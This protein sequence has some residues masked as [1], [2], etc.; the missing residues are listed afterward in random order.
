MTDEA[1]PMLEDI[2]APWREWPEWD[3]VLARMRERDRGYN[4]R[5]EIVAI[6]ALCA[7]VWR[8]AREPCGICG[9]TYQ[10]HEGGERYCPREPSDRVL[11]GDTR[12]C[13]RSVWEITL[14]ADAAEAQRDR[15]AAALATYVAFHDG[16]AGQYDVT[17]LDSTGA[18]MARR[19]DAAARA[20]LADVPLREEG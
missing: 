7:R 10:D 8:E 15:L 12:Y 4:D 11:N 5:Y 6:H 9:A 1:T 20:A 13:A 18:A 19:V 14:I 3:A 17:D 16:G 2:F